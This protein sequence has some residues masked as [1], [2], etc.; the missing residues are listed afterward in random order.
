MGTQA[1]GKLGEARTSKI[2]IDIVNG[3]LGKAF[4]VQ[5]GYIAGDRTRHRRNPQCSQWIYIHYQF[6]V[7]STMCWRP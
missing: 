4:G 1:A 3:T 5:G 7:S 2:R 6:H